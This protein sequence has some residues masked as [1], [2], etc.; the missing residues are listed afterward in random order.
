MLVAPKVVVSVNGSGLSGDATTPRD[1]LAGTSRTMTNQGAMR[2]KRRPPNP[3]SKT[4]RADRSSCLE[5]PARRVEVLPLRSEVALPRATEFAGLA[6][7]E[8]FC[9]RKEL[10]NRGDFGSCERRA[11]SGFMST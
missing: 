11:R 10:F 8:G 7:Q 2:N 5:N 1:N 6:E 9:E 3:P 4:H